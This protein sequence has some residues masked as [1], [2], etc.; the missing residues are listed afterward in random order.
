L[1][2]VSSTRLL[3]ITFVSFLAAIHASLLFWYRTKI[4]KKVGR[5]EGSLTP[6]NRAKSSKGRVQRGRNKPKARNPAE[7]ERD[8]E[9]KARKGEF[10]GEE[11]SQ[12]LEIRRK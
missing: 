10:K 1:K 2:W 5:K 6:G 12:K 9:P 8:N 7:I 4:G 3:N 11:T